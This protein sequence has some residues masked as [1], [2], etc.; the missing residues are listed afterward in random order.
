[1][2]SSNSSPPDIQPLNGQ[3]D[4]SG[5]LETT[6]QLPPRFHGIGTHANRQ[7][8]LNSAPITLVQLQENDDG[9]PKEE[10]VLMPRFPKA[11]FEAIAPSLVS[12]DASGTKQIIKAWQGHSTSLT[13]IAQWLLR[14]LR[15]PEWAGARRLGTLPIVLT[16]FRLMLGW[17]RTFKVLGHRAWA[18]Q[19]EPY[20]ARYLR[21]NVLPVED[22]REYFWYSNARETLTEVL[23]ETTAEY[24]VDPQTSPDSIAKIRNFFNEDRPEHRLRLA[25]LEADT[26]DA[27]A[28]S[29]LR[30]ME[31]EREQR[32]KER[33]QREKERENPN[34]LWNIA[35]AQ[36]KK[37][38][39]NRRND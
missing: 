16:S 34:N 24:L 6:I 39:G 36:A 28:Y 19:I 37:R 3:N 17:W 15:A 35:L 21:A 2:V 5:V 20:M 23:L 4:P 12:M 13:I 7:L 38:N 33:K 10:K 27:A 32:Q 22:M 1:M 14:I 18:N 25:R 9:T 31:K 26:G 11:I 30:D 8:W 29:R